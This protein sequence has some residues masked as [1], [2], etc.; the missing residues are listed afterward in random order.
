MTVR[1]EVF[2][3][4]VHVKVYKIKY[5]FFTMPENCAGIPSS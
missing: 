2:Y 5:G 3:I 1:F 4:S